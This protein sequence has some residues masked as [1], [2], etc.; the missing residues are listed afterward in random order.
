MRYWFDTEFCEMPDHH[1]VSL[2]LISIGIVAE[3]GREL[4]LENAN[5]NWDACPLPW[6]HQ[7]VRPHLVGGEAAQPF[8]AFAGKVIDF[9]GSDD[10]PEFWAYFADRDWVL[11]CGI[12]G[13]MMQTPPGWPM[14]CFDIKQWAYMLSPGLRLPE[15]SDTAHN[16]LNDA[17]WT[18]EAWT[19]LKDLTT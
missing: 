16:A 1:G 10:N 2:N 12:F 15:Q 14:L 13:G 4:Y 18:R 8:G 19:F 3:D 6:L 5:F 7:N 17:R 11:F 9:I